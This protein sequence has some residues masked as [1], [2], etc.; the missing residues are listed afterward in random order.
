[1]KKRIIG[2]LAVILA[3][4]LFSSCASMMQVRL[5]YP[6]IG[7]IKR[8]EKENPK[9]F[10]EGPLWYILIEKERKEW[11]KEIPKMAK[12]FQIPIPKLQEFFAD[13]IWVKR[14]TST[15]NEFNEFRDNFYRNLVYVETHFINPGKGWKDDRGEIYLTLGEPDTKSPISVSHY[16]YEYLINNFPDVADAL[17]IKHDLFVEVV[18][19]T[20]ND[21]DYNAALYGLEIIYPSS[22]YF[23]Q[24]S[25]GGWEL[26]IKIESAWAGQRWGIWEDIYIPARRNS[27][28]FTSFT[29]LQRVLEEIK[30]GYIYDDLSFEDYLLGQAVWVPVEEGKK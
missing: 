17:G 18:E 11:K 9:E 4:L 29:E 25:S 21:L 23:R 22:I 6:D 3:G 10:V 28:W 14:D 15:G 1:M 5:E 19:W 30:Q 13:Y 12:E 20:Y 27:Y 24:G 8:L 26:A 2:F 16:P 7:T